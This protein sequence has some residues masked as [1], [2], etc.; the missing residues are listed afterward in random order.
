MEQ[1]NKLK[2]NFGIPWHGWLLVKL[3]F[4][5]FELSIDVSDVPVNP[6]AQLCDALIQLNEGIKSPDK[7]IWHLEPYCYYLQIFKSE[8]IITATILESDNFESHKRL[9]KEITGSYEDI[10]LPLYRGLKKFAAKSYKA[11]HWPEFD[12]KRIEKLKTLIKNKPV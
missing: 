9:V 7:I 3:N 12:N 8:S 11:P 5:D 4:D 10:I 2:I 6:M 1:V